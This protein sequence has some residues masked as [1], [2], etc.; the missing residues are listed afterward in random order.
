MWI[1]EIRLLV[2][3][4]T[5][6]VIGCGLFISVRHFRLDK[7]ASYI[8]RLN[9]PDMVRTRVIIEDWLK[10]YPDNE[11]RIK[12][13]EN[14]TDLK[15]HLTALVNLLTELGIAYKFRLIHPKMAFMLWDPVAVTY[16]EKLEFYIKDCHSKG[17][18]IA[19]S[20]EEFHKAVLKH[21][22]NIS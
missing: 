2:A 7:T 14:D 12:A 19:L 5:L 21:R 3:L 20:F 4:L 6:L 15:F 8:Q 17:N 22:K 16:W 18:M 1:N 10:K 13:V 9:T 11:A